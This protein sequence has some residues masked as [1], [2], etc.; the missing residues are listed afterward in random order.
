MA[1]TDTDISS[2][3]T[4]NNNPISTFLQEALDNIQRDLS[5][6]ADVDTNKSI[7]DLNDTTL[8]QSKYDFTQRVFPADLGEV[9]YN[10][11][12]MVININV[13]NYSQFNGTILGP[14]GQINTSTK[15]N[16]ELS[17]VDALRSSIDKKYTASD[18]KPLGVGW[19]TPRQ[20]RRIVESIALFMPNTVAFTQSNEEEPVSITNMIERGIQILP[21]LLGS[22]RGVGGGT[23]RTVGRVLGGLING[24]ENVANLLHRPIN[25]R[26]EVIFSNTNL[27]EFRYDFLFSPTNELESENLKQIIKTMRFHAAPEFNGLEWSYRALESLLWTPPSEFDITYYNRGKENLA[28]PRIDTCVLKQCDVDYAPTGIYATFSNGYPVAVRMQLTF[29]ETEVIS[30]LRVLQGF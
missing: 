3:N 11:H 23:A 9:G 17:K 19:Y 15:L 16:N 4:L 7:E 10:G 30:K 13:S 5:V 12:Y 24:A 20:T 29:L 2:L 26:T 1:L 28:L 18:G 22:V 8:G 21:S 14:Q 6:L 25:P 27:R